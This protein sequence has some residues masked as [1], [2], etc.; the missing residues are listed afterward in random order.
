[1]KRNLSKQR[2]LW[3][4]FA[5]FSFSLALIFAVSTSVFAESQ[6]FVANDSYGRNVVKFESKAPLETII[7]ITGQV[8][9]EVKVDLEDVLKGI[10]ASFEVELASL[11][12]G[13][14]LRDQHM[15]EQYLETGKYP[16][17][18][19]TLNRIIKA[20]ESKL[21]DQKPV[22]ISAEGTFDLHG[23]KKK[24]R[25]EIKVTFL[26]ENEATKSRLPGDLLRIE[27]TFPVKLSDYSVKRP[28]LV[29]LKLDENINMDIN[30]FASNAVKMASA[31][32]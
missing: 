22:I 4:L 13:I 21:S 11:K 16:K 27:A 24:Q 1:M 3:K 6:V 29:L 8:K 20:S 12:T 14:D 17:A 19:F 18:I 7:G 25:V 5:S 28:Q 23:V 15:R 2:S 9:G 32:R 31:D 26:K 10:S 30:V